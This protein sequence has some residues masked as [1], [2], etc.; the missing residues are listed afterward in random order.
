MATPF[1]SRKARHSFCQ[2]SVSFVVTRRMNYKLTLKGHLENLTEGQG[3]N[4]T[5]KC[6]IAYRSICIVE[7]NT[8]KA[9]SSLQHVSTKLIAEKLLTTFHELR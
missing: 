8:S 5:A 4:L 1:D 7:L 6:H 3:Y 2:H 9:F